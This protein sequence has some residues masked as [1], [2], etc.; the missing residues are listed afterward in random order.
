MQPRTPEPIDDAYVQSLRELA[1]RCGLDRMGLAPA[2]VMQRARDAL[3]AR[4][5][6]GLHDTMQFTYRNPVRSTD[7]DRSVSGA[8]S[9]IV[10]ARSYVLDEPAVPSGPYAAVAR[11]AW[12]DHYAPL[13]VGLQ[14]LVRKLRADGY[15]AVAFAD[16]NSVVDR[17]AAWLG[18]LGWFGKNA[19]LLVP[20]AGSFF[21]LGS[22][23][24]TAPLPTAAEPVADGCGTCRRCIDACPTGA[25]VAPG[26]VD[27]GRCLAWLL[28]RPGVFPR[29][30]RRALGNRIYGCDECQTVCPPT[31]RFERRSSEAA[32]DPA[33]PIDAWVPLLELLDAD[34]DVV[35]GRYGRW[36]VADRN[37]MWIRRNALIALANFV[38]DSGEAPSESILRT[39]GRYRDHPEAVLR[40][41]AVWAVAEIGR[42][43]LLPAGDTEAIVLDEMA[44]LA[45]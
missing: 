9:M 36:Y 15:R 20:G 4:K 29:E 2:A 30:L 12:V 23:I 22:I 28:Q 13:R 16:D 31:V 41:H 40:A 37:P 32:G 26:V 8:Q 33:V 1:Q 7:P 44:A 18:G 3:E 42:A 45:R 6:A 34:D 35:L 21:V 17:E 25:I 14:Q 27:A 11:Y 24:T 5:A 19:N 10:A 43:D 38:R 39:L